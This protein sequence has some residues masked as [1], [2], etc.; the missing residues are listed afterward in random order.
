MEEIGRQFSYSTSWHECGGSRI[1][2]ER[3]GRPGLG[4]VPQ[5]YDLQPM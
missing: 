1:V 5:D 2:D 3:G 4:P